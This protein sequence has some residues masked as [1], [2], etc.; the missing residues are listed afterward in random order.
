MKGRNTVWGW[1]T[2][3]RS[4]WLAVAMTVVPQPLLAEDVT[5]RCNAGQLGVLQEYLDFYGNHTPDRRDIERFI[6]WHK[7]WCHQLERGAV[8]P[9]RANQQWDKEFDALHGRVIERENELKRRSKA[10][11]TG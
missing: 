7:D 9:E 8:H 2:I 3:P 10:I 1:R 5:G 11:Q 6:G 4:A